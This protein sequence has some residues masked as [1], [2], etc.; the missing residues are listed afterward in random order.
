MRKI[1]DIDRRIIAFVTDAPGANVSAI[2]AGLSNTYSR[3]YTRFRIQKLA[4]DKAIRV[5]RVAGAIRTAV[6]LDNGIVER[7]PAPGGFIDSCGTQ[8]P[9]FDEVYARYRSLAYLSRDRCEAIY[10]AMIESYLKTGV[11]PDPINDTVIRTANPR[12]WTFWD[13]A[14]IAISEG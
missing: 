14:Y 8:V 1:L 7:P 2:A 13:V 6:Y 12:E 4:D 11:I 5:D 10:R 9:G 3:P